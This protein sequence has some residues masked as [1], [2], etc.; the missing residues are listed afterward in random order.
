M[1]PLVKLAFR[2]NVA[3]PTIYTISRNFHASPATSEGVG[4][5]VRELGQK[6]SPTHIRDTDF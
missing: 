3:R 1:L 4:E 2:A 5:K 6:V